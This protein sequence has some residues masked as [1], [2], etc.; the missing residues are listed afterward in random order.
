MSSPSTAS[1]STGVSSSTLP[2]TPTPEQL[3]SSLYDVLDRIRISQQYADDLKAQLA[4][5]RQ[6]G[7]IPDTLEHNNVKLTWTERKGNWQ[8][9]SAV[10]NLKT[11]EEAEGIATR[12]PSSFFWT[13][14][15]QA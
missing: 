3:L 2:T 9:S 7:T 15:S 13:V 4:D 12:K 11:L 1:T 5:L 14:K 6:N 10:D 8:Y